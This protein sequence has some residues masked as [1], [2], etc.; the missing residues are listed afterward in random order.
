LLNQDFAKATREHS[1]MRGK[2]FSLLFF[3]WSLRGCNSEAVI[4]LHIAIV[5]SLEDIFGKGYGRVFF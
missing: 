5:H 3:S 1:P 2:I 4:A